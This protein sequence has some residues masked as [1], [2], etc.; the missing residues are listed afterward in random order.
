MAQ[1]A[2]CG[3]VQ[4]AA[5]GRGRGR[6]GRGGGRPAEQPPGLPRPGAELRPPA[7]SR[8]QKFRQQYQQ[9]FAT[10]HHAR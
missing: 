7:G 9:L 3:C 6:G 2:D 8:K 1:C 4:G 5:G 10:A